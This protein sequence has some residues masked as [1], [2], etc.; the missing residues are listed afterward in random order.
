MIEIKHRNSFPD[1]I[2]SLGYKRGV[3]VGSLF[4]GYAD[5]L[6][7]YTTDFTL[8]MVD[9]WEYQVGYDD[10]SNIEDKS[11]WETRYQMAIDVKEKYPGRCHI[12]RGYST[13][14]ALSFANKSLD[15]I[16][17]DARH[18]YK[19][20][21]EDL[22]TWYPKIVKDGM[23]AGHD[24]LDSGENFGVKSAVLEFAGD[25]KLT[26]HNTVEDWPSWY[27]IKEW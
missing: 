23:F 16:Y 14:A 21:M 25:L 11:A 12:I 19:H 22:E 8:T 9:P 4:G 10:T 27:F 3:E 17:L 5:H 15:F 24:F 20:V 7:K 1:L 2:N 13:I 26:V 6:L 18:D